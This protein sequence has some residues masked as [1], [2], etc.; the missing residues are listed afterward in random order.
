MQTI[1]E[2]TGKEIQREP[3]DYQQNPEWQAKALVACSGMADPAAEIAVLTSVLAKLMEVH[4]KNVKLGGTGFY[5]VASEAGLDLEIS[6]LELARAALAG[7]A[8]PDLLAELA[9]LRA[10]NAELAGALAWSLRC[11]EGNGFKCDSDTIRRSLAIRKE[12]DKTNPA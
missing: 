7:N 1:T 6:T 2:P 12:P 3:A 10:S 8:A 4:D 9:A 11:L 5:S